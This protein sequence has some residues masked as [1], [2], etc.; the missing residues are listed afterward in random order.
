[1]HLGK[2]LGGR[3]PRRSR[4]VID[5]AHTAQI[6]ANGDA[7]KP[8][9]LP[10]K[11]GNVLVAIGGCD[12]DREVMTLACKVAE[13]KRAPIFAVYGIEVPR[14]KAIDDEMPEETDKAHDALDCAATVAERLGVQIEPEI[15]Q[16]RHFGHSLVDE[17][18]AHDSA[19]VIMSLPCRAGIGGELEGV[20]TVE[21]VLRNAPCTVWVVRGRPPKQSGRSERDRVSP[22]ERT[23]VTQ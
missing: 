1:M 3:P 2:L 15:I 21:Y 9:L 7:L 10:E 18:E 8:D 19:L 5:G 14:T 12:L 20:D 11:H 22:P 4:K 13:E 6:Q 23:P 16:S 17:A